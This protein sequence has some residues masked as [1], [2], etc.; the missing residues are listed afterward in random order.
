M[1]VVIK[2][3]LSPASSGRVRESLGVIEKMIEQV[4]TLTFELRPLTLDEFGLG[5]ALEFLV[6]RY[7][8]RARVS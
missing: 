2:G 3:E 1:R 7:G 8:E 5:E 4:Q 6:S